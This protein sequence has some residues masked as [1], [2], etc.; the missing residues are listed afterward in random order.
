[1]QGRAIEVR[2]HRLA[3]GVASFE[4]WQAM[5]GDIAAGDTFTVT[6]GCDKLFAT[7]QAKFANAENFRGFPH[8]P[9]ND[10][11]LSYAIAGDGNDDGGGVSAAASVEASGPMPLPDADDAHRR[12]CDRHRD[13]I[14]AEA[15]SW[16]GTPY[17]HQASLKGVG[18]DCLGLLRGV[19]RAFHGDEPEAMPAYTPDWAEATG[20]RDAGRS[21]RAASRGDPL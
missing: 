16:L 14:V 4:L 21:G 18:C 10:F 3:E 9:G 17:R 1:M 20:R 6:A 2:A 5:A 12:T 13:A 8:M 7:C 11:V 15:T 19:W